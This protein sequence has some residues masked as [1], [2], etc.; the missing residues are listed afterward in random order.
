MFGTIIV[1]STD[2]QSPGEVLVHESFYVNCHRHLKADGI[3]VTQNGVPFMHLDQVHHTYQRL[4][5]HF[6][7]VWF[8]ITAMPTHVGGG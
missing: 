4:Q 1:D 5:P 7:D 2:P 6:T 8:F 3:L